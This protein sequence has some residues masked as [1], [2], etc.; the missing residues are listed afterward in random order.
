MLKWADGMI[1]EQLLEE[2]DNEGWVRT[3]YMG[4]KILITGKRHLIDDNEVYIIGPPE[5][6]VRQELLSDIRLFSKAEMDMLEWASKEV[7]GLTLNP[8]CFAKVTLV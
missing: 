5:E 4:K 3:S 1:S 6:A 8:Y 7:I 2:V